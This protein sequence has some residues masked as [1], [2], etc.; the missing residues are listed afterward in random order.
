MQRYGVTS[1]PSEPSKVVRAWKIREAIE[2]TEDSVDEEL[3][4]LSELL[5]ELSLAT[6]VDRWVTWVKPNVVTSYC[7]IERARESE[8][9]RQS[10][11]SKLANKEGKTLFH[12]LEKRW[13]EFI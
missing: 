3:E 12:S 11:L 4:L 13:L 1:N 10:N 7:S 6:D 9:E 2:K 5:L 8:V